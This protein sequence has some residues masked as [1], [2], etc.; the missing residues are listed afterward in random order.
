MVLDLESAVLSAWYGSRPEI[1]RLRAIRDTEGLRVL[2]ELEP[3]QDSSEIHP[4]W[5]AN[6]RG[7]ADELRW[8]MDSAIRL[9]LDGSVAELESRGVIVADLAWRDPSFT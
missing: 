1:R 9:E 5:M 7:W 3:A 6:R 8:H 2:I 4:A